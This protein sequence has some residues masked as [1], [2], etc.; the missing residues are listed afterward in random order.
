MGDFSRELCGGTHATRSGQL[1]VI[2]LVGESSIGSGVRRVE[3]LVGMDAYRYLARENLLVHQ[4]ASLLNGR[5]DE[6]PDI[7]ECP[8]AHFNVAS[9][10]GEQVFAP[11]DEVTV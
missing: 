8:M 3:A 6:M 10:A 2:T 4:I 7:R 1:G 5:P 11:G 9:D